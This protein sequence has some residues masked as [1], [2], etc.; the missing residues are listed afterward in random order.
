M[1]NSTM[2]ILLVDDD[3]IEHE[4]ISRA[5]RHS[6]IGCPLTTACDGVEALR[7]LRGYDDVPP[8]A[9]PLMILLDL[10]MPKMNGFEFLEE[11]R[12][13]RGLESAVVFILSTSTRNDDILRAYEHH[14]AGFIS[15]ESAH[16]DFSLLAG[17]ITSYSR[18]M[19]FA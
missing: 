4:A 11:L 15:K 10:N 13:D 14:V 19:A 2:N 7:I 1:Q 6:G 3:Q 16:K 9:H 17:F 12:K 5:L 8:L 18:L